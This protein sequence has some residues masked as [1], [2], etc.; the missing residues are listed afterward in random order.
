MPPWRASVFKSLLPLAS[1]SS[2][3]AGDIKLYLEELSGD[4]ADS[5]IREGK[6]L[7]FLKLYDPKES[8][9]RYVGALYVDINSRASDIEP[10]LKEIAGIDQQKKILL[11]E[12]IKMNPHVMCL[13]IATEYTFSFNEFKDGD[14]ICYQENPNVPASYAYPY[15]ALFLQHMHDMKNLRALK[16]ENLMLKGCVDTYRLESENTGADC[17]RMEEILNWNSVFILE[18]RPSTLHHATHGF[19]P[20]RLFQENEYGRVYRGTI[21]GT[22][23]QSRFQIAKLCLSMRLLFIVSIDGPVIRSNFRGGALKPC[24]LCIHCR[25]KGVFRIMWSVIVVVPFQ[26]SSG[27]IECG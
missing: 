2:T 6:I 19:Q 5:A 23:V 24:P 9:L 11:Y 22:D 26:L 8:K 21:D 12:E 1:L 15:V 20:E 10:K 4:C 7:V 3:S 14:I 17:N 16:E 27:M 13:P 25:P 18:F